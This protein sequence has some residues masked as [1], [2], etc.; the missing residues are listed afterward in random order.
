MSSI[1]GF[2]AIEM[3]FVCVPLL[4]LVECFKLYEYC[5]IIYAKERSD[6]T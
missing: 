5:L 3:S 4:D 2:L 6:L 1:F